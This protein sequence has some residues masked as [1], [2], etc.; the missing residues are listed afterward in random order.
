MHNLKY[1]F[2]ILIYVKANSDYVSLG[3]PTPT[4]S[5]DFVQFFKEIIRVCG[6]PLPLED[7]KNF[8]WNPSIKGAPVPPTPFL[9]A[10]V[11]TKFG[12]LRPKT[13]SQIFEGINM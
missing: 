7:V 1:I 3:K 11:P 2:P 10:E 8:S 4:K 5:D 12:V 13:P 6:C 9:F